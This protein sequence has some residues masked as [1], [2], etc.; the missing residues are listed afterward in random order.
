MR[1]VEAQ[2]ATRVLGSVLLLDRQGRRLLHGGGPSL[3]HAYNVAIH[4]ITIGEG[5]GS[6]GTAAHRKSP[7]YVAD[8]MTD[9]LWT[10]FRDLAAEHGLR[11]CWS[12]PILSRGG[13]VL[14]T[15]AMY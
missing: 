14:G 8:I 1:A 13:E 10:D 3:P 4:G 5:V 11:A 7:V 9:P 15:Y 6:C 2:S 12:T